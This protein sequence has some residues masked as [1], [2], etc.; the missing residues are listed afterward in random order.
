M[1]RDTGEGPACGVVGKVTD[2]LRFEA[3]TWW[4]ENHAGCTVCVLEIPRNLERVEEKGLWPPP[5]VIS[6]FPSLCLCLFPVWR[7]HT[8]Y[9]KYNNNTGREH[10]WQL[11]V[12]QS[13]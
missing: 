5:A 4:F 12:S 1:L 11:A 13:H 7:V 6:H 8:V 10:R 2:P 3:W 9:G